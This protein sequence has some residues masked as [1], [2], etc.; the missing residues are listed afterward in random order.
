MRRCGHSAAALTAFKPDELKLATVRPIHKDGK[1]PMSDV[2]RPMK[3]RPS[4]VDIAGYLAILV[5]A[6]S[7]VT[8]GLVGMGTTEDPLQGAL[9]AR[10]VGFGGLSVAYGLALLKRK[11]IVL[12]RGWCVLPILGAGLSPIGLLGVGGVLWFTL[13]LRKQ[14]HA[15]AS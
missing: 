14:P 9:V 3:S 4:G 10:C 5:G 7:L 15:F 6:A 13:R 11:K 8:G 1:R 12:G 2:N